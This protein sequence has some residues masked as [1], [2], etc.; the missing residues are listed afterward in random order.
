MYFRTLYQ[1]YGNT[2]LDDGIEG[3]AYQPVQVYSNIKGGLGIFAG[4]NET[5]YVFE[6]QDN[7][8]IN[9]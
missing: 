3:F 2:S 8:N 5:D 1:Q 6:I 4:I 7:I 9:Y